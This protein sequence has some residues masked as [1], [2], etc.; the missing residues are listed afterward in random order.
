MD[1]DSMT[2]LP[3]T[4]PHLFQVPPPNVY[5]LE[6]KFPAQEFLGDLIKPHKTTDVIHQTDMLQL[7][8]HIFQVTWFVD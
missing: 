5:R 2:Q 7:L 1:N 6:T 3:P 4:K 8:Y